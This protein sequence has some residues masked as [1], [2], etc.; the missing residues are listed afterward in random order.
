MYDNLQDAYIS[1]NTVIFAQRVIQ[2]LEDMIGMPFELN[3]TSFREALFSSPFNMIAYIHFAGAIQGEYILALDE[4]TAA[5]LT[6]VYEDEMSGKDLREMREDY[7]GFVKELLNLAVGQSISQ[8]EHSFGYL[9]YTPCTVVYGEID[10]PDVMSGNIRIESVPGEILC[11]F[12]LDLARLKIGRKLE[13]TLQEL[14]KKTL[15][16]NIVRKEVKTILQMVLQRHSGC[17]LRRENYSRT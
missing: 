1:T 15:E 16:A 3:R 4:I 13:E 11:G 2:S 14:E 12:S 7:G 6:E 10:F 17:Q 9:T 8:L 5:K